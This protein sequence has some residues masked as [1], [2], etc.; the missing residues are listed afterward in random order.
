MLQAKRNKRGS[1]ILHISESHNFFQMLFHYVSNTE[2]IITLLTLASKYTTFLSQSQSSGLIVQKAIA[3]YSSV[4]MS[5]RFPEQ[6]KVSYTFDFPL[7][8]FPHT[9]KMVLFSQLI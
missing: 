5:L 7:N 9:Q 3:I 4:E 2:E 8:V 1:F 6:L